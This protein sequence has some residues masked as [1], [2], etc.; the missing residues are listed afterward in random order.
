VALKD[1]LQNLTTPQAVDEFL[2]GNPAAAIFK[3]GTC[4]KTDEVFRQVYGLLDA[5]EDVPVGFI[6][7]VEARP[8]S[9]HVA[10][11]T[12][13]THESPQLILFRDGKA[14]FDRDNWDITADSL[15]EALRQHFAAAPQGRV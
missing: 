9:N 7:V 13:I 12:G 14:V 2:R 8:A 5:R 3:A 6:R 11:L 4:H 15:E 1:R 10:E